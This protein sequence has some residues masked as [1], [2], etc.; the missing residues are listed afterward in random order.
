MP[1]VSRLFGPTT[2]IKDIQGHAKLSKGRKRPEDSVTAALVYWF[3]LRLYLLRMS[4]TLLG[5]ERSLIMEIWLVS[6]VNHASNACKNNKS[7]IMLW[8]LVPHH[9]DNL[10]TITRHPA[11]FGA[12]TRHAKTLCHSQVKK[13]S[14]PTAIKQSIQGPTYCILLYLRTWFDNLVNHV[15]RAW[16]WHW[17]MMWTLNFKYPCSFSELSWFFSF[18]N[19]NL[20]PVLFL[21]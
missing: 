15:H 9:A 14:Y 6:L 21:V 17:K 8:C 4:S 12:I 18:F 5:Q 19:Q 11:N 3:L 16:T 20:P 13:V 2:K 7:H 1:I 10:G